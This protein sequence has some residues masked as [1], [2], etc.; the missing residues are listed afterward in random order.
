[1]TSNA[2]QTFGLLPVNSTHKTK[3]P[4]YFNR[5]S[6]NQK[7]PQICYH[8][9]KILN[10]PKIENAAC[11]IIILKFRFDYFSYQENDT[12]LIAKKL[13]EI[14]KV[15]YSRINGYWCKNTVKILLQVI[16]EGNYTFK[17]TIFITYIFYH[18]KTLN[19]RYY[20]HCIHGIPKRE[21]SKIICFCISQFFVGQSC[22]INCKY[23]CHYGKCILNRGKILCNCLHNFSGF[24]C[25]KNGNFYNIKNVMLKFV[26]VAVFIIFLIILILAS[27]RLI[28]KKLNR[29]V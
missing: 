28:M 7:N 24:F 20:N 29:L 21:N 22:Q 23:F 25:Y 11:R 12:S 10:F 14:Q 19:S 18:M 13:E 1:M 8:F 17:T 27:V 4:Q 5:I 26:I 2:Y 6:Y 15:K 9:T 16:D 3:I